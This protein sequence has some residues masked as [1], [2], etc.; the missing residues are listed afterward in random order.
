MLYNVDIPGI[1]RFE[2]FADNLGEIHNQ[3]LEIS[4]KTRN[5]EN[6]DFSWTTDFNF[7]RNRNKINT[8]L[9]FDNDGDGKEDDLVS[10]GLFIG[11]STGAIFDYKIDGFWQLGDEIPDGYEFGSYKVLDLN[12]D[13]KRD[14]SDR[15]IIGDRDPSYRLGVNNTIQYKKFYLR[16]FVNSVQSGKNRYLGADNL[17]DF[18]ILNSENHFNL[19]FPEGLDYWTPENP[20]AFYQRPG[21]KGSG[22]I[23][24]NRYTARSFVRLKDV[25]LSYN[26][27]SVD[28]ASIQNLKMSLSGRNI[29]T[30]TDWKGWDPETGE[31]VTMEGRPVMESYSLSINVTF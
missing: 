1:N 15:T 22:G 30:I 13:G 9:G 11:E 25:S 2:I 10:E 24:G 20:N 3:G 27:G 19:A 14:G 21:I 5:I 12:G 28:W 17:Y 18:E 31:G 7:S 29:L 23:A 6:G 26:L 16:I 8:L 4:L